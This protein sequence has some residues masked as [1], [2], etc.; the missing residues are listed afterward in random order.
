MFMNIAS[1]LIDEDHPPPAAM[2]ATAEEETKMFWKVKP[3][4]SF[5]PFKLSLPLN[6]GPGPFNSVRAR[7]RYVIHGLVPPD[8]TELVT[9]VLMQS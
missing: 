2:L 3:S 4:R 5:L 7:I 9:Q 1:E 8:L 6:V